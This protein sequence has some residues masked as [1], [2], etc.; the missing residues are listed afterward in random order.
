M[1]YN[2]SFAACLKKRLPIISVKDLNNKLN[3]VRNLDF[4]VC[5]SVTIN[6]ILANIEH[7]RLT[8]KNIYF[9]NNIYPRTIKQI[10]FLK[11]TFLTPCACDAPIDAKKQTQYNVCSPYHSNRRLIKAF[12]VVF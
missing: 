4:N 8:L 6:N 5:R 2:K 12:S 1:H 11:E 9:Y 10:L 7:R 3:P